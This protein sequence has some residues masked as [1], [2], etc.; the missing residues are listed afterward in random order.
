MNFLRF[1]RRGASAKLA[2]SRAPNPGHFEYPFEM[3]RVIT[4]LAEIHT[5]KIPP[6]KVVFLSHK[7][8]TN[9]VICYSH[10]ANLA[11]QRCVLNLCLIIYQGHQVL[12]AQ[13]G[14]FLCSQN[15]CPQPHLLHFPQLER[16]R[17]YWCHRLL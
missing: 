8:S 15:C 6:L 3:S 2:S 10:R 9:V 12:Q 16:N 5:Q 1:L 17:R 11:V 13:R 4:F 14:S 7:L